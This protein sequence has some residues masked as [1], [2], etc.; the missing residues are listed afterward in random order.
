MPNVTPNAF[1]VF[2]FSDH[3]STKPRV[4]P[5]HVN[6]SPALFVD[7]FVARVK[8]PEKPIE[9]KRFFARHKHFSGKQ[10][11]CSRMTNSVP[12]LWLHRNR[13]L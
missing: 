2:S 5:V 11:V 7:A 13:K 10:K 6:N 12:S 1:L 9:D 4:F 3:R 8:V